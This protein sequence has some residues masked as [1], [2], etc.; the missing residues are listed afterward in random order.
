[1]VAIVLGFL[2][3]AIIALIDKSKQL[4]REREGM[5]QIKLMGSH[6]D[7]V[8]AYENRHGRIEV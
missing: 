1:M 4:E 7:A 3:W 5:R 8:A 2:M 6:P